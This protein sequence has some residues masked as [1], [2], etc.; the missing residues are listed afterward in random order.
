MKNAPYDYE[1]IERLKKATHPTASD[2]LNGENL[3][4]LVGTLLQMLHLWCQKQVK[5]CSIASVTCNMR[6]TVLLPHISFQRSA[7]T[8]HGICG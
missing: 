2:T 8:S 7:H 4:R 1:D 5:I 3:V 6:I